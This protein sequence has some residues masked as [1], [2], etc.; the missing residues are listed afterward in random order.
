M[1]VTFMPVAVL[2]SIT[3]GAATAL[4]VSSAARGGRRRALRTTLGN[5]LGIFVWGLLAAVGVAAI[6]ATSATVFTVVKL[7]GALVLILL[8]LQALRGGRAPG[9]PGLGDRA[10]R[11]PRPMR[12]GLVSSLA[13]PKLAVF[14]VALFPQFV[15]PGAP[16]L[17]AALLMAAMIVTV[18]L[19]WYSALAWLVTRVRRALLDG[20]WGRRVERF[21]GAVLIGLGVRLAFERR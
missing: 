11:E 21:T 18:D 1:L 13:N 19:V 9:R 6:V 10:G 15:P 7:A 4:V 17:P 8:G 14:F 5:S 3:P 2:L 20:P 16:V 12:D